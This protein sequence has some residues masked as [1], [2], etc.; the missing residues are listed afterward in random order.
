MCEPTMMIFV[1]EKKRLFIKIKP[2]TLKKS[3]DLVA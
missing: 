1:Q 3:K 2:L